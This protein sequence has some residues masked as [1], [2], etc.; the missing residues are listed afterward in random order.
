[1]NR[2]DKMTTRVAKFRGRV[3][4]FVSGLRSAESV[5]GLNKEFVME[6][7]KKVCDGSD[8]LVVDIAPPKKA[9]PKKTNTKK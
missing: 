1:M 7:G 9:K 4:S 3:L 2:I 8:C 5:K 6:D